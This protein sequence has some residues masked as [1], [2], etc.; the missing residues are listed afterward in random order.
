MVVTP[1]LPIHMERSCTI[2]KYAIPTIPN[3]KQDAWR[4]PFMPGISVSDE[5]L[6]LPAILVRQANSTKQRLHPT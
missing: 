2:L 3:R 1:A 4:S 5:G 6:G